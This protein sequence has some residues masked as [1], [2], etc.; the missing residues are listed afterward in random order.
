MALQGISKITQKISGDTD[1]LGKNAKLPEFRLHSKVSVQ[2]CTIGLRPCK[3]V[4]DPVS[5]HAK[6]VKGFRRGKIVFTI[7][8][9]GG[10]RRDV[11]PAPQIA[12]LYRN[13]SETFRQNS[14]YD[15]KRFPVTQEVSV[16]QY[17]NGL[18]AGRKM[19]MGQKWMALRRFC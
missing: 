6:D 3:A 10:G 14:I 17:P 11:R 19:A 7:R 13:G 15:Q 8:R 5:N 4:N 1:I 18:S 12:Q 2:H 16:F 9:G